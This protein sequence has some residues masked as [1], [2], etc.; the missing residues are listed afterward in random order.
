L[1]EKFYIVP[2]E[3]HDE[4]IVRAFEARGY[5]E[6]E[7]RDAA[8]IGREAARHGIRTHNAI[9][10]L[11]LDHLFGSAV[12]GCVPGAEIREIKNRFTAAQVW[13]S[14]RKLGPSVAWKAVDTC[15]EL[16]DQFGIGTVSVDNAWHYFWGGGYALEAAKRGYVFYTNCTAM[17]AE[18]V[19]FGGKTPT[20]GTNPHTWAF[21][22]TESVGFPVLVD[23]ATSAVAMGR[24]QQLKRE[25]APLPPRSAVD[26]EGNETTDPDNVAAL[27]PFGAHKGYGLGLVNELFGAMIGGS[28][29]TIRGRFPDDGEKHATSFFFMAV[30]PEAMSAGQ[31]AHGR[32]LSENVDAVLEDIRGH[33]N[34]GVLLP[35]EIEHRNAEFARKANGLPFT[36]AEIAAFGEIAEECGATPWD[37]NS[38]SVVER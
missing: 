37:T 35:G 28:L 3:Q 17:L 14:G 19:P 8:R 26:A 32:N 1:G 4:L 16:A 5:T 15:I 18:V 7:S 2:E 36:E 33:Q 31:F 22:E 11:H 20:L 29:P 24:V 23:W 13:D 6:A 10:A 27:L 12:G 30:H 38:L 21:P 34:D 25:G 9:K